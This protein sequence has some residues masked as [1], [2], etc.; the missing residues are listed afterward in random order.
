MKEE[1]EEPTEAPSWRTAG[2]PPLSQGL[3]ADPSELGKEKAFLLIEAF[4]GNPG[5]EKVRGKR[6]LMVVRLSGGQEAAT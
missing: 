5:L 4:T 1:S 3:P 2:A 6:L